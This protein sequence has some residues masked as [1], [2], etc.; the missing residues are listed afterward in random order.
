MWRYSAFLPVLEAENIVS[1]EEG[2]TPIH[3]FSKIAAQLGIYSVL[4]K[5]ES[6]NPTG[7]F[8]ADRK[9]VV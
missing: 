3:T 6:M 9:S 8:K 2:W 4:L 5:D 7:S 1:L